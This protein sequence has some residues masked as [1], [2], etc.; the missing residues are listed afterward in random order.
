MA[1]STRVHK[2]LSGGEQSSPP[3][4]ELFGNDRFFLL[5]VAIGPIDHRSVLRAIEL[6]GTQFAPVVRRAVGPARPR[7]QR[8]T[9]APASG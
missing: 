5:Q 9:V 1:I 4:L 3:P 8:A 2:L 6:Y 7:E